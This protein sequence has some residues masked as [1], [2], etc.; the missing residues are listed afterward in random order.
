VESGKIYDL[1]IIGGSAAAT[2]A[3]IYA[4]RR[5][6]NFRIICK[7]FGGEV[8]TSGEVANWPGII[9]TDGFD[10]AQQ[11]KEHLKSYGVIPQEGVEVS[12]V[13]KQEDGTFCITAK[14][15]GSSANAM[16]MMPDGQE[17]APKCDYETKSVIIAT[18]VHPK[19]LKIP[20]EKEYRGKGVTYCTVCDGPLFR[21]KTVAVLGGGNSALE[22]ALMLADI[23]P[24]VYVINK[25]DKFKGE[26]VLVDKLIAKQNVQII[27][28]AVTF[29]IFGEEFVKGFKYNDNNG[30]ENKLD[31]DGIFVHIGMVPNSLLAPE[32][33]TKDEF[34]QIKVSKN[35]ETNIP[36]VFA[37]GDVTD[38]S[39]KQIVIASGQGVIAALATVNYLNKLK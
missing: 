18:G 8:A 12:R 5:N 30:Q 23:C 28:N 17:V 9:K 27:F 35:C 21:G 39:F 34:G 37:A 7:D 6:L 32:G 29:E 24:K 15:S 2:S 1:V 13:T 25:N 36:G 20:G 3:A 31:V 19:E 33:T 11:F 38:V 26:Q 16:E 10:L 14:I 4:T 22:A